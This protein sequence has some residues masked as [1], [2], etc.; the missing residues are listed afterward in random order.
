MLCSPQVRPWCHLASVFR[1][2]PSPISF[3]DHTQGADSLLPFNLP[4]LAIFVNPLCSSI[5]L[6]EVR[7]LL[8]ETELQ[9]KTFPSLLESSS[10]SRAVVN[11]FV[12]VTNTGIAA[13]DC[14]S[15]PLSPKTTFNPHLS[16]RPR[17]PAQ[18]MWTQTTWCLAS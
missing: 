3:R 13:K 5:D 14:F 1:T 2:P 7:A 4:T 11:Y 15:N 9:G 10:S 17:P 8:K 12:N 16:S 18:A 6:N